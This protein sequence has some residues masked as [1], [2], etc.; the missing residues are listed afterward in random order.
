M[1]YRLDARGVGVRFPTGVRD[2]AFPTSSRL[3]VGPTQLPSQWIRP[4]F[5]KEMK[6]LGRESDH[7][8]PSSVDVKNGGAVSPFL[9]TFSWKGLN[10]LSTG[11]TLSYRNS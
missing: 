4:A 10:L 7:S 1:R 9:N 11:T 6:W 8:T 3:A 2:F 5:S